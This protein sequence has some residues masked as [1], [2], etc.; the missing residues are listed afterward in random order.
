[1]QF[2]SKTALLWNV[3]LVPPPKEAFRRSYHT[4]K[5][6]EFSARKFNLELIGERH[7][8]DAVR[9]GRLE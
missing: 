1:M 3:T 8:A 5:K 2:D 6:P 7:L 4:Q 9:Q